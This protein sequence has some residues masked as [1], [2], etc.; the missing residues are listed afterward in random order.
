MTFVSPKMQISLRV[1][2]KVNHNIGRG[3]YNVIC[4]ALIRLF[5]LGLHLREVC[6]TPSYLTVDVY[7][8]YCFSQ[9]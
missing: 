6:S 5:M 7:P 2:M 4:H 3:Q 9:I 1:K 8:K